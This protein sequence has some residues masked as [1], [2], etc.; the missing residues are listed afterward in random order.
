MLL[1]PAK[2]LFEKHVTSAFQ[3]TAQ[4]FCSVHASA[5]TLM[6]LQNLSTGLCSA[7]LS[8]T[9]LQLSSLC[10]RAIQNCQHCLHHA[11]CRIH[12]QSNRDIVGQVVRADSSECYMVLP[13]DIYRDDTRQGPCHGASGSS[14]DH[15]SSVIDS[16]ERAEVPPCS[17]NFKQNKHGCMRGSQVLTLPTLAVSSFAFSRTN[18]TPCDVDATASSSASTDGALRPPTISTMSTSAVLKVACAVQVLASSDL[19]LCCLCGM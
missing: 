1:V 7:W 6:M 11:V 3:L 17:D 15:H 19:F 5:C 10:Q 16:P 13:G 2:V 4:R 18:M 9:Y 12:K 8:N 14:C